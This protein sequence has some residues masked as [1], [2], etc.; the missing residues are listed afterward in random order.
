MVMVLE[1]VPLTACR[2]CFLRLV[3]GSVERVLTVREDTYDG[4]RHDVIVVGLR[5][6]LKMV[7]CRCRTGFE[8]LLVQDRC[9]LYFPV[10]GRRR[11]YRESSGLSKRRYLF[12]SPQVT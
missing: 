12:T 5:L 11:D 4:G 6:A 1:G 9:C 7:C 8:R 10:F 3:E 2:V